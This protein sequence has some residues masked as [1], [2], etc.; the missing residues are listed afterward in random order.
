MDLAYL[1]HMSMIP[2]LIGAT[3]EILKTNPDADQEHVKTSLI[4]IL[5]NE[6]LGEGNFI[7]QSGMEAISGFDERGNEISLSAD[8]AQQR[9]DRLG[10][11]FENA[12]RIASIPDIENTLQL[13]GLAEGTPK[14]SADELIMRAFG[15]RAQHYDVE[16]SLLY[17]GNPSSKS[18]NATKT[19]VKSLVR[20]I[21]TQIEQ[22]TGK[23][24]SE[25]QAAYYIQ[26]QHRMLTSDPEQKNFLNQ[27]PIVSTRK[28][29]DEYQ[30]LNQNYKSHLTKLINLK[31]SAIKV[32]QG[33]ID[34]D[35]VSQIYQD[36]GL[37]TI[38]LISIETG[39]PSDL[40]IIFTDPVGDRFD[41]IL[42]AHPDLE[43]KNRNVII[44]VFEQM[45]E[46]GEINAATWG[47]L[48]AYEANLAGQK[49]REAEGYA[50]DKRLHVL[51]SRLSGWNKL[52]KIKEVYPNIADNNIVLKE[53]FKQGVITGNEEEALKQ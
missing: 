24:M 21:K 36:A 29:L 6:F 22:A 46:A 3:S 47:D 42:R 11:F 52:N 13:L 25:Q 31:N 51:L 14:R 45:F 19:K 50:P 30:R 2:K 34:G 23:E 16:R 43:G 7:L 41:R 17:E 20:D 9:R 12:F 33:T 15:I 44:N 26:E 49:L 1:N 38:A 37:D 48:Q 32:S 18:I 5:R 27:Q 4:N 39:I 53:L 28:F 40:Q 35:R 10:Y 8:E